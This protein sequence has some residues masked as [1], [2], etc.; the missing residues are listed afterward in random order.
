MNLTVVNQ[1]DDSLNL[2][3]QRNLDVLVKIMRV[4]TPGLVTLLEEVHLSY[5]SN[6]AGV[7]RSQKSTWQN[8]PTKLNYELEQAF[9]FH[10]SRLIYGRVHTDEYFFPLLLA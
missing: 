6:G 9:L 4:F 7:P 10:V 5:F 2:D 3:S 8:K 1:F